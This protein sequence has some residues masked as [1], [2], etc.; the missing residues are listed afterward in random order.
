ML[1]ICT[2]WGYT[3]CYIMTV[4]SRL[5]Y[6]LTNRAIERLYYLKRGEA[7][8]AKFSLTNHTPSSISTF[9][10]LVNNFIKCVAYNFLYSF[11]IINYIFPIFLTITTSSLGLFNLLHEAPIWFSISFQFRASRRYIGF[12]SRWIQIN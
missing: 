8:N 9:V 10:T 12:L 11:I 1:I 4:W 7:H 3:N 6:G 2:N 5:Q